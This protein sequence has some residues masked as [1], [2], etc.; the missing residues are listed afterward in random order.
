MANTTVKKFGG[1]KKGTPNK[2]TKKIRSAFQLI[3]DKNLNN[4]DK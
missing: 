3:I 2:T 4:I 1:R